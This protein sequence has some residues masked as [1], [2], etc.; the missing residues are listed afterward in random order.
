MGPAALRASDARVVVTCAAVAVGVLLLGLLW[1]GRRGPAPAGDPSDVVRV[2]VVQGQSVPGYLNSSRTELGGLADPSA[3]ASGDTWALVSL[4]RYVAAGRLPELLEGAA[5]VQV[6][7]RVPVPEQ[8]TQVV[9]IPVYR[10][11][12]DVLSGMLDAAI[13]RDSEKASYQQLATRLP[14]ED[15][16]AREAYAAAARTAAVEAAAYRSGCACVFAAVV[17]GAPAALQGLASRAAVRAVDPAPEV[18]SLDRTEFR[19]PLPEQTG[20]VP[21]SPSTAVPTGTA[22]IA[23]RPSTP[24]GSAPGVDVTSASPQLSQHTTDPSVRASE[25]LSA[26]PSAS[27]ATA[28]HDATGVPAAAP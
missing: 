4:D 15:V 12:A 24:I 26:V 17:R 28:A 13:A 27:D 22:G 21:P 19:P 5:V 1:A 20:T 6:Y 11:P 16:R 9:R 3:P 25:D 14:V 2:G 10:L 7:A 23:P 8:H 18:R